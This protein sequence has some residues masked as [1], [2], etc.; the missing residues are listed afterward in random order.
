[1]LFHTLPTTLDFKCQHVITSILKNSKLRTKKGQLSAFLFNISGSSNDILLT[2]PI[3]QREMF[4][5]EFR[6]QRLYSTGRF[7]QDE[8]FYFFDQYSKIHLLLEIS[9]LQLKQRN[10]F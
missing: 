3:K 9:N 4:F 8:N 5:K 6:F 7:Q 2:S 1:M 10:L